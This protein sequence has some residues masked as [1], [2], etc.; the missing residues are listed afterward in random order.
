MSPAPAD[1]VIYRLADRA[2]WKRALEDGAYRGAEVDARD[3]YIHFST[4]GQLAETARRHYR[5]RE[6]IVL[7]AVSAAAL[8]DALRWEPSRGGELFP[9]LYA[10]LRTGDVLWAKDVAL[11]ADGVPVT[12]GLL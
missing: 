7:L 11:D 9:H 8:G 12:A 10:E 5:G 3:G 1:T 6:N 4:A 2:A